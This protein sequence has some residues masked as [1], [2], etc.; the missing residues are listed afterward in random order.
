MNLIFYSDKGLRN[1]QNT[2]K[3]IKALI[4]PQSSDLLFYC[5]AYSL[6]EN[7]GIIPKIVD[8]GGACGENILF[9]KSIVGNDILKSSFVIEIK[10]Q[11]NESKK[12]NYSKKNKFFK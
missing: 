8:Y 11:V 10:A 5:V 6:K 3:I 4:F 9:L 1:L 7:K 2:L 12:W